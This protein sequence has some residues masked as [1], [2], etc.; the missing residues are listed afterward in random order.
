MTELETRPDFTDVRPNEL[1]SPLRE[2]LASTGY[3]CLAVESDNGIIHVCH[4]SDRDIASF[5]RAPVKY[6]WQLIMM[7]TAPLIR[8]LF[9]VVD[10]PHNPYQFES[11]LNVAEADQAQVLADLGEQD[12]F[13]LAFYGDD[14]SYRYAKVVAHK[15]WQRQQ[16]EVMVSQ[17]RLHWQQIAPEKRDFDQAKAWFISQ[18]PS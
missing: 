18:T 17:A 12:H 4:V 8:L 15:P 7:P 11:F 3:G 6:Q 13:A 10:D 9:V 5:K 14:L 16:L 1:P 2:L